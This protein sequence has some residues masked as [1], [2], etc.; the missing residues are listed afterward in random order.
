MFIV[1]NLLSVKLI[2]DCLKLS[3]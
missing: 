3:A 1:T 2:D